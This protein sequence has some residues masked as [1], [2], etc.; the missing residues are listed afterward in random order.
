LQAGI[1]GQ[2]LKNSR[3]PIGLREI[4]TRLVL[5]FLSCFALVRSEGLGVNPN[6]LGI[7]LS[8]SPLILPCKT[9]H[10]SLLGLFPDL[11]VLNLKAFPM[12]CIH[13]TRLD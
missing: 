7:K 8:K 12:Q 11:L 5:T 2:S 9:S 4:E 13:E 3:I 10:Q 1:E 6:L